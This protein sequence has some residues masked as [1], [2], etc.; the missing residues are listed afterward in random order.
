MDP[1]LI[2]AGRCYLANTGE[3]LR[4]LRVLQIL[5]DGRV[6]YD[7]RGVTSSQAFRRGGILDLRAFARM[8]EREVSADT[9]LHPAPDAYES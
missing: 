6:L 2:K 5:P 3:L 8:A 4:V 1:G 9:T 7:Q